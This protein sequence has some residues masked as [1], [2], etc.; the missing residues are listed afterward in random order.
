MRTIGEVAKLANVT[1]RTLH[2]YDEIGLVRPSERTASG[3]RL[4]DDGDLERLQTVLF[5]REL[6]FGL[7]DIAAL[8]R[9]PGFDRGAAL[10]EQRA[11]LRARADRVERMIRAVDDAITAHEQGVTMSDEAMFEVFGADFREIQ[12][13]AEER[14]GDTDAYQQSRQRTAHYTKGDWEDL[15]AESERITQRIAEVYRSGAAADSEAAMDAVE[16][17]RRQISERFYDCSHDMQVQLGEM[18]VADPRF[19]ATY[20]AIEPGLTVWVRDAINANARRAAA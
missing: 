1:V 18:Y 15:K 9:E 10:R 20:E 6:G 3:Y 13:E 2:H 17:H 19:T 8:L 11:L 7:D 16:A 5:Y 12:R 4:Y 14:W